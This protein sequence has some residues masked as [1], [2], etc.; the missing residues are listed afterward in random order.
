M[1]TTPATPTLMLTMSGTLTLRAVGRGSVL[2]KAAGISSARSGEGDG[3][4]LVVW[5]SAFAAVALRDRVPARSAALASARVCGW[6]V[7]AATSGCSAGGT[8]AV[9]D[10]NSDWARR[11][12]CAAEGSVAAAA[13]PG[14][15]F[16]GA[17]D[18]EAAVVAAA[19]VA[20]ADSVAC[21]GVGVVCGETTRT[22]RFTRGRG[23]GVEDAAASVGAASGVAASA[24]A[25][26]GVAAGAW[27]PAALG[28]LRGWG[29][30]SV[31]TRVPHLMQNFQL[32][33]SFA[34]QLAQISMESRVPTATVWSRSVVA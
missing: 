20:A 29:V 22:L 13:S 7:R 25:T 19:A 18:S 14:A 12:L 21:A 1:S 32:G 8:D 16:V 5:Y 26:S 4:A 17:A 24:R 31:E 9:G 2:R 6:I 33:S 28:S 15:A 23:S 27:A 3:T 11:G 10:G 30:T 34:A